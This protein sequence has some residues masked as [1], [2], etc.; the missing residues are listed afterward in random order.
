MKGIRAVGEMDC[1]FKHRKIEELIQYEYTLHT[2]FLFPE[3]GICGYDLVGMENSGN[4]ESLWPIIKAY[5][6]VIMMGPHGSFALP[7]E[8]LD[9][10]RIWGMIAIQL[11][12]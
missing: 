7:Q 2:K 9:D 4:L 5:G 6:L 8:K 10:K 12:Q 11:N 1:F 3:K